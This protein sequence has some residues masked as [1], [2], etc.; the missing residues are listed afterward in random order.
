MAEPRF[1]MR[2]VAHGSEALLFVAGVA[3]EADHVADL[4]VLPL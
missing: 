4:E 2:L 3:T 1:F